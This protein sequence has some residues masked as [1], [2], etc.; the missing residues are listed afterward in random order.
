MKEKITHLSYADGRVQRLWVRGDG[1]VDR[2]TTIV[3][4]GEYDL[5]P[6]QHSAETIVVTYGVMIVNGVELHPMSRPFA[7]G[8]G[9]PIKIAAKD[10]AIYQ[11]MIR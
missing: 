6:V 11:S 7:L 2:A 5:G 9:D 3:L 8:L 1:S 10:T 4:L